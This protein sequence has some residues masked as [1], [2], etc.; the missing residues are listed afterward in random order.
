M[1]DLFHFRWIYIYFLFWYECPLIFS[2]E[3]CFFTGRAIPSIALGRVVFLN[4]WRIV[5]YYSITDPKIESFKKTTLPMPVCRICDEYLQHTQ[6]PKYALCRLHI[7][8]ALGLQVAVWWAGNFWNFWQNNS[9]ILARNNTQLGNG[10]R[11]IIDPVVASVLR[12]RGKKKRQM[13]DIVVRTRH[14]RWAG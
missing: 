13:I 5:I 14:R 12:R 7:R 1:I 4:E 9:F 8:F 2:R 3:N 6:V 10:H 11:L